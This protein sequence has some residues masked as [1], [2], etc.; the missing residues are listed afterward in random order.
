MMMNQIAKFCISSR[1][2]E[3]DPS[4]VAEVFAMLK[5]VPLRVEHLFHRGVFEYLA[6]GSQFRSVGGGEVVPEVEIKVTRHS[7]GN[8]ISAEVVYTEEAEAK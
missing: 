8:P 3:R 7:S 6:I 2:I 1:W 4:E 5:I